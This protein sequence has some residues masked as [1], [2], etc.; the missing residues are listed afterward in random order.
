M[1]LIQEK[2]LKN[3]EN[4]FLQAL[5]KNVSISKGLQ[6]ALTAHQDNLLVRRLHVSADWGG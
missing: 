6:T 2:R 4:I 5:Q 1:V 3:M